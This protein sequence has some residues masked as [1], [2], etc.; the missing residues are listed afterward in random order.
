[1]L[2][3]ITDPLEDYKILL[4]PDSFQRAERYWQALQNGQA[5]A[6][7]F[8]Q[9]VFKHQDRQHWTTQDFLQALCATK[10]PR[11]FAESEVLGDGSD[12]T[13]PELQLLGDI[14]VAV[15]VVIYDNARH[16]SPLVHQPPFEGMLLYTA[17]ALLRSGNLRWEPA[18]WAA[19][20]TNNQLD[21]EGY[22][23]L[24]VQR[25]WPVFAYANAVA[26]NLQKKGL[27]TVPGLG[28][29]QFAGPFQGQLGR[30]LEGV[31][32][33]FL[34]E[35]GQTF[36]SLQAVYYDPYSE[37]KNTRRT[38][39]HLT[40]LTRPLLQDNKE[41]SQLSR[42]EMFNEADL[43]FS[44]CFLFS[45]V[46]W[47]QVSWPGN[48]FYAGSRATDDGVK[49]AATDSMFCMTTV[50]GTYDKVTSEYKPPADYWNWGAVIARL[51]LQMRVKDNL[52]PSPKKA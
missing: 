5:I 36:E 37:C 38:I 18:D 39:H 10:R 15:P 52:W 1:M 3:P 33:R 8:L 7:K 22:Y 49:A 51:D 16:Q 26:K 46:A 40:L 27:V 2:P 34:E 41:K 35:Y 12:W 6:G 11:I 13:M 14:G 45:L 24:Y 21:V 23:Q 48:D 43:D 30:A 28:C 42:P 31:L 32:V 20:V 44:D 4:H 25:L 17:G 9:Q 19:C 50:E 29:G 47:D